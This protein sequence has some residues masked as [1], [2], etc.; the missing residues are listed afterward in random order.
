MQIFWSISWFPHLGVSQYAVGTND[1]SSE[2]NQLFSP[3]LYGRIKSRLECTFS[4]AIFARDYTK[5][6]T[7]KSSP[8]FGLILFPELYIFPGYLWRSY[9]FSTQTSL[10]SLF[11]RTFERELGSCF[12]GTEI[13]LQKW[14]NLA[15]KTWT[16][17]FC[18][19]E[20]L[21]TKEKG[22]LLTSGLS[23]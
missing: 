20:N 7:Q 21:R 4:E 1:N 13:K 8:R 18:S 19:L 5:L 12:V 22:P 2:N 6:A 9:L 16:H 11:R 17:Y 14:P 15:S 10:L 23:T 3:L